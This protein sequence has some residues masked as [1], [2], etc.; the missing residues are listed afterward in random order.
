MPTAIKTLGDYLLVKR[1]E[2]GLKQRY[3]DQMVGVAIS[4]V[5]RWETDVEKPTRDEWAVL[6]KVLGL[7]EDDWKP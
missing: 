6:V 3:I 7:E 4:T 5:R 2:K 1:Y